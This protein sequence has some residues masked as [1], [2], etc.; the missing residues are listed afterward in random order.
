MVEASTKEVDFEAI[1]A[2]LNAE[3]EQDQADCL[4]EGQS[5]H[6]DYIHMDTDG[7]ENHDKKDSLF[8]KLTLPSVL[9]LRSDTQK[10][11]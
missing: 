9:K 5:H 10:L 4:D 7:L 8:K 3:K 2:E 6:P 11:D 1:G